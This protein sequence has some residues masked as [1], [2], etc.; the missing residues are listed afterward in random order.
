MQSCIN[1]ITNQDNNI[2]VLLL[3]CHSRLIVTKF[4][5]DIHTEDRWWQWQPK[6]KLTV[7]DQSIIPII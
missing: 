6:F 2:Q 7:N 4:S 1:N 3:L 5:D